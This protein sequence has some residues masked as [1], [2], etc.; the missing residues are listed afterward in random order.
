MLSRHSL[1][2][3]SFVHLW[4]VHSAELLQQRDLLL[5]DALRA[6][7]VTDDHPLHAQVGTVH[8]VRGLYAK[9]VVGKQR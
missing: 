8:Q 1:V 4:S 2:S 7:V 9:Q 6:R 3:S 5:G